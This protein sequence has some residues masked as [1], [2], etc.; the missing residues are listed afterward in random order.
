[1]IFNF[2]EGCKPEPVAEVAVGNVYAS[3]NTHK[4]VAWLV[5]SIRSHSV[6]M[7]GID[8]EGQVSST[9]SYN[10]HALEGRKLLGRVDLSRLEFDIEPA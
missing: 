2:P 9:Q 10:L 7:V 5:L 8:A 6:H 1:M 3:K 4:T